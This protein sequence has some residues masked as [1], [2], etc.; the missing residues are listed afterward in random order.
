MSKKLV[1]KTIYDIKKLIPAS[2]LDPKLSGFY[3]AVPDKGYKDHAFK[4]RHV[5]ELKT[6][7]GDFKYKMVERIVK[8]WQKDAELF[9][10]FDDQWG[11]GAYT[12]GY[13]KMGAYENTNNA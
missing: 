3:A 1:K 9:R 2:D 12:L 7:N 5:I 10:R 11:R 6:E 13:F 8:D 4:I